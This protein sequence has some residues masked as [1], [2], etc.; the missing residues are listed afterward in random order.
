VLNT[1]GTT[2]QYK[3]GRCSETCESYSMCV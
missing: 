3:D 2:S 1:E